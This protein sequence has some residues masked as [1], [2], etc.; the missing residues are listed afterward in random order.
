MILKKEKYNLL[1]KSIEHL[2]KTLERGNIQELSYLL[3]N[4]KEIIKRNLLARY[5]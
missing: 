2:S 5:I 3:G 1:N 4:K